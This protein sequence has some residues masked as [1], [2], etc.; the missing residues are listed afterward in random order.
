MNYVHMIEDRE[1]Y[2]MCKAMQELLEEERKNGI[3]QGLAQGINSG[4]VEGA[5][6]K[7][8]TVI[9]NMLERGFSN[10]DICAIA[11][12]DC[13]MIEEVRQDRCRKR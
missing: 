10:E 4:K 11:D 9:Q 8:R 5:V 1:E 3:S 12:C 2:D 13:Q 7:T 6:D